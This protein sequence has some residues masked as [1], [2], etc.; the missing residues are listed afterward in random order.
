ML[1]G[2]AGKPGS[3]FVNAKSAVPALLGL[4]S[5]KQTVTMREWHKPTMEETGSGMEVTSYLPAEPD[6]A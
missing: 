1:E 2:R 3:G 4:N 6:R 5:R